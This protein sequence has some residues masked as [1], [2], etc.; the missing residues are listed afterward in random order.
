MKDRVISLLRWSEKYTKT[1]MHYLVSGGFWFTLAQIVSSVASLVLALAF[2]NFL[3][4]TTYGTYKYIL[5]IAGIF[6]LFTL[7]NMSEA[8]ARAVARGDD[9]AVHAATRE[10]IKWSFLGVTLALLGALYYHFIGHNELLALSL[11]IVACTLPI[12]DTLVMYDPYLQ[13][14]R[15]FASQAKYHAL[16]QIVSI[17]LLVGTAYLTQNLIY[18]LLA[19]FIPVIIARLIINRVVLRGIPKDIP[20]DPE[21]LTYGKHLTLMN[22]FGVV[23]SNIDK[24]L[25][26]KFLGAAELAIYTFAIAI[27]EQLKGPLKGVASIAFPK[28]AVQSPEQIRENLPAL[29]RKIF[30]YALGLTALS[31]AYFFVA[32]FIYGILFP[33]YTASVLYSQIFMFSAIGLVGTIP[34]AVLAAHK[35]TKEQY[36]FFTSQPIL[37]IILF[38]ICIPLWGIMGAIIAR[39][40]MRILYIIQSMDLLNRTFNTDRVELEKNS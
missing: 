5:S 30:L 40:I 34:L 8:V 3:P 31:V 1:D 25:L 13:G 2:A 38:C 26:F 15:Q 36:I 6:A 33:T 35:K 18:I 22:V 24:I 27:P 10:R 9:G 11:V 4:Q 37:Q 16:I 29:R 14:K 17:P 12:F 39:M 20:A 23:A 7:P 21:T 19:Y 28:F 32:P